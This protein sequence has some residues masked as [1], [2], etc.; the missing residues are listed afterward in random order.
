MGLKKFS[1]QISYRDTSGFSSSAG[2][3]DA[4]DAD[5]QDAVLAAAREL[6]WVSARGGFSDLAVAEFEKHAATA[7]EAFAAEV[8]NG[9]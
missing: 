6:A 5:P 4:W 7:R 1:A 3:R 2:F 9:Q 8:E